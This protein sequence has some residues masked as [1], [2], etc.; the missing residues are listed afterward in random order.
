[1]V[2]SGQR[3]AEPTKPLTS[4]STSQTQPAIAATADSLGIV[5]TY[6]KRD[7]AVSD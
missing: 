1:M 6:P 2:Q 4:K 5:F 3:A 7:V